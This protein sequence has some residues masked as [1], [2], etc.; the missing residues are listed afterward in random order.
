NSR[1]V[2]M[3]DDSIPALRVREVDTGVEMQAGQTLAIAGLVQ[4]RM[5]AETRGIPYLMDI[6]YLGACFRR[7]STEENEVELLILVTPE[8]VEAMDC[9][10][11]PP[12]IGPGLHTDTP[13]DCE[14]YGKGY[15]EV[16]R[17]APG[18]APMGPHGYEGLPPGAEI[19]P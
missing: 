2:A 19:V 11:V 9:H 13:R 3:G 6:P 5:D 7:V 4:T 16:P 14:L 1:A 8:L 18:G 10:E 12:S 15:I 17:C